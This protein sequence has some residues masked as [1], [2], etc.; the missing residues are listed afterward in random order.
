MT[1]QPA[2]ASPSASSRPPAAPRRGRIRAAIGV[3]CW[4]YLVMALCVWL[5]L[6][7]GGD[8]WWFATVVLFGPRWLA[9]LPVVI[10]LPMA[11]VLRRRA[12]G[13][14]IPAV[15]IVVFPV[16]GL[17]LPWRTLFAPRSDAAQPAIRVMTCNV[18]RG[19]LD[20]VAL[21]EWIL[22]TRPDV[23]ALQEWTS[24]HESVVSKTGD[25]K[26]LRDGE[27]CLFS[28]YP[29]RKIEDLADWADWKSQGIP[30][31]AV[32]YELS[33]PR[34]TI[35]LFNLHL[36]SP[37]RQ[38][39]AVLEGSSE[40]PARVERNSSNRRRQADALSRFASRRDGPVILAGDFNMPCESGIFRASWRGFSDAFST[41]GFGFG[42]TYYA[43][44][45][46]VRIDYVLAGNGWVCRRSW[47]GPDVGSPHRPLIAELEWTGPR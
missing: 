30:G 19:A 33:T 26:V 8:H 40:G 27:L 25:W 37:H 39:D 14:L 20:P 29:I 15:A 31:A 17:C 4:V 2:T 6:R 22:A 21:A 16:M 24:K 11:I 5:L 18:H 23:V 10:L 46:V 44:K 32:C 12:L 45:T 36:A 41:A 9:L 3:A 42:Y 35:Y 1:A 47:V 7:G 13:T 38:L 34:K 43:R 28:R